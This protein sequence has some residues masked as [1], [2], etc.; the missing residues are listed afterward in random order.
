M[1]T[2]RFDSE[3]IQD[4][5]VRMAHHSSGLE[6]NTITLPETV[7]II[8]YHTV[9]SDRSINMR[10]IYEIANHEQAFDYMFDE[11]SN[12][13]PLTIETIKNMHSHLT[14]RLQYDKGKFKEHD[15]AIIGADFQTASAKETSILML[16]WVEN[17]SY[18]L[19]HAKTEEEKVEIIGDFHIQFER[20]H[21]FSDGNGRTGRMIMNYSLLQNGLPP[22]IIRKEQKVDYINVLSV[23]DKE[24]FYTFAIPLL[25]E[26]KSIM[27]K[28][29]NKKRQQI[30]HDD[31]ENRS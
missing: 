12:D 13:R 27:E 18:Q 22:L 16:Q 20:I 9:N 11:I 17:L 6:G 29:E 31:S 1:D 26:E 30:Q 25:E 5:L 23:V 28:F 10:E 24:A 3:Y 7:S 8:L 4:V 2:K 21:P 15:N 14:D 19:D